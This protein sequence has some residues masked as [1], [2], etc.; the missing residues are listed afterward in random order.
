MNAGYMRRSRAARA[1]EGCLLSLVACPMVCA[2]HPYWSIQHD[3]MIALRDQSPH[4]LRPAIDPMLVTSSAI[5]H[6]AVSYMWG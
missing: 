4:I 6:A 5:H 2:L 1:A 3:Q